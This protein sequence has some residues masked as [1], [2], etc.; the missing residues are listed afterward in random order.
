MFRPKNDSGSR[1]DPRL[2][3]L[4]EISKAINSELDKRRLLELVMDSV[5]DLTGAERGF[6]IL[7]E[8][9]EDRVFVARNVDREEVQRPSF[10]ISHSI[11]ESVRKT[12]KAVLA[13]DAQAEK[14]LSAF[15]SVSDLRLRSILCAP[16]RVKDSVIGVL[17]LDHR[18][19][20]GN[21]DEA[22]LRILEMFSEQAAVAIE[23]SRLHEE[24]RRA[25]D[26][27][28]RL[29]AE[30]ESK[31]RVQEEEIV[32]I[33]RQLLER[34]P[35]ASFRYDYG[36]I[37]GDSPPMRRLFSLLDRVIDSTLP[38][39]LLGESG[40]G[41]ELVARTIHRCGPRRDARFISENCGA[42][43][44]NLL[45]SELFGFVKGAF[46]GADRDKPG[47]LELADG[48]TLFLDEIGEM[49]LQLQKKLLRALQEG[50]FRKVGGGDTIRVDVRVVSATNRDLVSM[51][52]NGEFREDLYY[53]LKG[54]VIEIPPLRDRKE[55]IPALVDAFLEEFY[56][57]DGK[58]VELAPGV[59]E[60]LY[61]YHWPGNVREL[62]NEIR[63]MATLSQ[64]RIEPELAT[65]LLTRA[66]PA[67]ATSFAGRT[68]AELERDA[69][70]AAMEATGG[71][72]S[73]AAAM[74]GI[75]RRTFYD[76]LKR[77]EDG[78]D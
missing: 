45:E 38:V 7:N 15:R 4:H 60:I 65:S 22:D 34:E 28:T 63:A 12:G 10:K 55:D 48:G 31:V 29:N 52:E 26:E 66:E 62:E 25:N 78:T 44:E 16:F 32:A 24:I 36:H 56:A 13:N 57:A 41:K 37:I 39:L 11:V 20:T 9:G 53:R 33:R 67:P 46:T 43:P 77:I 42:I 70:T 23:N 54:I 76:K 61:R 21:F 69:I 18:F 49:D 50:E 8:G 75:P 74:L 47:L 3:K 17:Y 1:D 58:R 30:L 14:G 35:E 59:L 40:T 68:L 51:V 6:L 64:D 2:A 72:K 5:I 19:Q 73:A 71:K 27:L